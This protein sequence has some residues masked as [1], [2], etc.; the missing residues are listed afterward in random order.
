MASVIL[1]VCKSATAEYA[2]RKRR[3]SGGY[4]LKAEIKD[5]SPVQVFHWP[6]GNYGEPD[7]QNGLSKL[8]CSEVAKVLLWEKV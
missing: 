7:G 5:P 4:L 2:C 3:E 6:D 8:T 1:D